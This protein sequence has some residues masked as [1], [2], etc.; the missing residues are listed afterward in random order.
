M[1]R[2]D[3]TLGVVLFAALCFC[4]C[5]LI[6]RWER[7]EEDVRNR[8]SLLNAFPRL[9]ARLSILCLALAALAAG[10]VLLAGPMPFLP[11]GMSAVL[12][13]ILDLC[14]KRLSTNAA[15]VLA[16]AALLT[17]LLFAAR[18]FS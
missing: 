2:V 9:T 18:F 12:L 5:A 13:A 7:H 6:T 1:E 8:A 4:N 15:R 11:L 17:P 3:L 14:H 10:A 16:D